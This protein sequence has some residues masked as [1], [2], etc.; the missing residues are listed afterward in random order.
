VE[1]RE[2]NTEYKC[3]ERVDQHNFGAST[4]RQEVNKE[5]RDQMGLLKGQF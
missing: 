4:G 2:V 3:R 5:S 1:G